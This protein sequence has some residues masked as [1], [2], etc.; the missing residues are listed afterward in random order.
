MTSIFKIA[1]NA[2]HMAHPLSLKDPQ[3]YERW[4]RKGILLFAVATIASAGLAGVIL[5][6]LASLKQRKLKKI[7]YPIETAKKTHDV[8]TSTQ[9]KKHDTIQTQVTTSQEVPKKP[10]AMPKISKKVRFQVPENAPETE[11]KKPAVRHKHQEMLFFGHFKN[12]AAGI[13]ELSEAFVNEILYIDFLMEEKSGQKSPL[14]HR[15]FIVGTPPWMKLA[16]AAFQDF[17]SEVTDQVRQQGLG[18]EKASALFRKELFEHLIQANHKL[19]HKEEVHINKDNLKEIFSDPELLASLR[20]RKEFKSVFE[21][22][23]NGLW[24]ENETQAV[25]FN[26]YPVRPSQE[27]FLRNHFKVLERDPLFEGAITRYFKSLEV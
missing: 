19:R 1:M 17:L 4:E 18:P 10:P 12:G 3:Q 8:A 15:N 23:E 14:E 6:G 20:K 16:A 25:L 24:G 2:Y 13:E 27:E 5:L 21:R 11:G 7:Q 26:V 22:Y 9:G